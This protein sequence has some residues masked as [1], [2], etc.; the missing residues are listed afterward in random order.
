M[1][2][3]EH[4]KNFWGNCCN[5]YQ[6]EE[7]HYKLLRFLGL[8]YYLKNRYWIQAPAENILDVGGGPTSILLKT[9]G[10]KKGKIVDPL[11]Y[12]FWVVQRYSA[13][14]IEYDQ[15][16]A[17]DM[18]ES[19]W[20]EVWMYNVLQHCIDPEKI[21]KNC[22][23]A[24]KIFRFFDWIDTPIYDGHPHSLSAAQL[25]NWMGQPGT[26]IDLPEWGYWEVPNP[27]GYYSI[28]YS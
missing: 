4:E 12:P 17:E 25:D 28:V 27:V 23:K 1:N 24:G 22:L 18:F 10:L 26:V 19:G 16:P 8:D 15:K 14:N 13:H 3:A 21:I 11:E 6:E 7:K 20:G 2:A 9:I 5:T